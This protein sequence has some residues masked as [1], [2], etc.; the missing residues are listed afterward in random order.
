MDT[1]WESVG[2]MNWEI[3]I[4]MYILLW[5][6][7]GGGVVKNLPA[8]AGNAEDT[9]LIPGSQKFPR[10]ANG[11]PV[12]LSGKFHGQRS[13]V[14]YSLVGY[15]GSKRIRH[16]TYIEQTTSENLV[17]STGNSTWCSVVA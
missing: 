11:N 1:K 4:D 15:M 12:F 9:G 2:G 17:R 6:F 5:G 10:V 14:D 7:P 8:N 13:L 3:G 16:N